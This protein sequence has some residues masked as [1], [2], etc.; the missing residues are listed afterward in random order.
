MKVNSSALLMFLLCFCVS[1]NSYANKQKKHKEIS[2]RKKIETCLIN[3]N[4]SYTISID[5]PANEV[6][7]NNKKQT[8][9][10]DNELKQDSI[11]IKGTGNKV[12]VNKDVTKDKVN[13]KQNGNNNQ[14]KIT[15][16]NH[17]L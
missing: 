10:Q 9:T 13:V 3:S 11:Q 5:G 8:A 14:V 12:V 4:V 7:V 6:I 15:Q 16:S 1:A 2:K 17:N